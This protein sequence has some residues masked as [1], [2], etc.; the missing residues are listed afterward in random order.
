MKT[1]IINKVSV[2]LLLLVIILIVIPVYAKMSKEYMQ[3]AKGEYEIPLEIMNVSDLNGLNPYLNS[4]NEFTR[5]AAARRLGEVGGRESIPLLL[6]HF[7]KEL[8]PTGLHDL[9]LVKLEIVR[10]LKRIGGEEGKSIL[11][12][13]LNDYWK[14]GPKVQDKKSY[15]LDRDYAP[16]VNELLKS[17]YEW[18]NDENVFQTVK[19]IALNEDTRTYYAHPNSIGSYAWRIY[20]KGQAI[21]SQIEGETDFAEYLLNF[22]EEVAANEIAYGTL[23]S[24]QIEAARS[25]FAEERS[26]STMFFLINKFEGEL[27]RTN[28]LKPD[29]SINEHHTR[30]VG[31]LGYIN[32]LQAEKSMNM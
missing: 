8:M 18:S 26:D 2:F 4:D 21:R 9:P 14:A 10:V 23:E 25:I 13:I 17:L 11:L 12:N 32:K 1:S 3:W 20:L 15:A 27:Q 7:T 30:L 24:I 29:G 22:M 28:R 31:R 16:I 6:E 5:M 19:N